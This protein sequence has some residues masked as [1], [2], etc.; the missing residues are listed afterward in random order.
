VWE[1]ANRLKSWAKAEGDKC[2]REILEFGGDFKQMK[3]PYGKFC[4][5]SVEVRI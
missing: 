2:S 5:F 1:A 4:N 3:N